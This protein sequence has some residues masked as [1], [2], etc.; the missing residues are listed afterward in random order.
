MPYYPNQ[1]V[2]LF[3]RP[4]FVTSLKYESHKAEENAMRLHLLSLFFCL[5]TVMKT[6]DSQ[7]SSTTNNTECL[8]VGQ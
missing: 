4:F 3:V 7:E 8:V 2:M 5:C 1:S 6:A